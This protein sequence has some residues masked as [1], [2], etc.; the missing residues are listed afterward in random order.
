M[1]YP[2]EVSHGPGILERE[3]QNA[4]RKTCGKRKKKNDKTVQSDLQLTTHRKEWLSR[5][6]PQRGCMP[7]VRAL[8]L[9]WRAVMAA[10]KSDRTN[11]EQKGPSRYDPVTSSGVKLRIPWTGGWALSAGPWSF[12]NLVEA[13]AGARTKS[14][15]ATAQVSARH[16]KPGKTDNKYVV[17]MCSWSES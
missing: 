4:S 2:A 13:W 14:W 7:T 10:S 3:L 15:T 11:K 12:F 5:K 6:S 8:L 9:R 16:P 1:W 17:R